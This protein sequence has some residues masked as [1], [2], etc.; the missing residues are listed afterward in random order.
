MRSVL[1][2]AQS[3]PPRPRKPLTAIA[4]E[5]LQPKPYRYER[6]DPGGGIGEAEL[7]ALGPRGDVEVGL[8]DIDADEPG[9]GL[10][11]DLLSWWSADDFPAWPRLADPE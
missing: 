3:Q 10:H 9:R 11:G 4:I 5:K 2:S 1:P 8:G 6:G 7:L